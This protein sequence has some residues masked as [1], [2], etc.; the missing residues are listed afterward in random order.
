MGKEVKGAS[1]G[2]GGPSLTLAFE[3]FQL[4]NGLQVIFH[5]DRKLPVVHVNL[6]YHVGS[7]NEKPGRTGFAHLFEHMMFAGSKNVPGEYISLMEAAGANLQQGGVNGT[8][9]FDRTNYFETL[10]AGAL[11]LALWAESDRMGFLLDALTQ[12]N[13][14]NQREVVKN[15]RRQRLDNVPYGRWDEL[16]FE[17]LF[18]KGHPYSW[19]VI[20]S[21]EDLSRAS[22]H[23]VREFFQTFYTPNNCTLVVAGDFDPG[24]AREGVERYFAPL[25]PGP[26]L[27]RP[28]R[29]VPALEAERRVLMV[30][31]VPQ[32]RVY[33]AWPGVPYFEPADAVLDLL[34][35]LLAEGKNSRLYKRL[36]YD[37]QVASDVSAFNY[38]LEI[39]GIVGITATA[40]PGVRLDRVEALIDEELSR[41]A[42]E[43]PTAEELSR[44]KAR[45]EYDFLAGLERIGGF[46]GKADRL[47]RYHTFLGSPDFLAAD[48]ERYQRVS[49]EDLRQ[50]AE[51]YLD[52]R[53]LVICF[54]PE[55]ASR[56]AALDFD[57]SRQPL[58]GPTG[59]FRIPAILSQRLSNGMTLH[60]VERPEIPLVVVDLLVRGGAA[61]EPPGRSGLGFMVAEVLD[62]GTDS[63]SALQI[64]AELD[65]LGS[66]LSAGCYREWSMVSLEALKRNLAPS[67]ALM[68]DVILHPRFPEEELERARKQRLDGILQ[69]RASASAT[70][71]RVA[72]KL[73]F[74]P[75]HPYGRSI[76]GEEESVRDLSRAELLAFYQAWYRPAES[77]I[78]F[79]GDIRPEE[80]RAAVG[81]F[82]NA[83]PAAPILLEPPEPA[84]PRARR[85]Y[86]V[87]RPNSAQTEIRLAWLAPERSSPDRFAVEVLNTILGGG[88]TSRLNLNLREDKGYAYGAFSVLGPGRAQ[89]M[90]L[91]YAPVETSATGEALLEMLKEIEDLAAWRRPATEKELADAQATLVRGYAQRFETLSQLAGEVSALEGFG[92]ALSELEDYA[93]GIEAVNAAALERVA[94]SVLRPQELL[95]VLVGDLSAIEKRLGELDLGPLQ[96]VDAEGQPVE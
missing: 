30:D 12:E 1:R 15:E 22:L 78:V 91:A 55:S 41:F 32:E 66:E 53:R 92:M 40:R 80:A 14:D 46:G 60:V 13:L 95:V 86:G 42:A 19:H 43:G 77:A 49:T 33:L 73:L 39:A 24:A 35:E 58:A 48:Y 20:G 83:W 94:R 10:P 67:L 82:F 8:T 23:D 93:A 36:V 85:V 16:L 61:V 51:K 21:M 45:Q 44:V 87:D 25:P 62:E 26:P 84:S 7:K 72:R 56:P 63:R 47:A 79:A 88:F 38:S 59:R 64:E 9:D 31:R 54:R 5:E 96:R 3:A 11:E 52:R 2:G 34:S 18:P 29:W 89:S 4:A 57:R 6:W 74:G 50:A 70:A 37:E 69:D 75:R 17:N 90:M 76:A 27:A 65:R 68:A 71:S 81:E 28:A